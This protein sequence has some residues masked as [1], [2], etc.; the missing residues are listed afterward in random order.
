LWGV[1]TPCSATNALSQ[2]VTGDSELGLTAAAESL[3]GPSHA[4]WSVESGVSGAGFQSFSIEIEGP[5]SG[6]VLLLPKVRRHLS[7]DSYEIVTNSDGTARESPYKG[8]W[9]KFQLTFGASYPHDAPKVSLL[10]PTYHTHV[11]TDRLSMCATLVP[12]TWATLPIEKRCIFE[13]L[14]ILRGFLATPS[15][16]HAVNA[17][18]SRLFQEDIDEYDRLAKAACATEEEE[19]DDDDDA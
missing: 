16:D 14:K 10:T 2:E 1:P 7:Q 19:E 18:A 17:D 11:D 8:A 3:G 13:L 12:E 5:V 15:G 9:F 4:W 6:R